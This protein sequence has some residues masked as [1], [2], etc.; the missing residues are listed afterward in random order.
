LKKFLIIQTAFIGDVVL[1]TAVAE[2][3]HEYFP[4]ASIDFMLRKGN[5]SLLEEHPYIRKILVW[6]KKREKYSGLFRLLKTVRK[7]EYDEV[8][9]MQR[10][11]S[12][13]FLTAFSGARHTSGFDKNPF[14]FLF[15]RKV[16]HE[17]TAMGQPLH[18]VDRNQL[19]IA[20][21]TGPQAAKPRLYPNK[22]ALETVAPYKQRP[23]ICIAPAS[24]WFTKQYPK[25]KWISFLKALPAT[26]QVYII[27]APGDAVLADEITREAGSGTNIISLC[28]K[29]S[30]LQ[31]AA[32]QLDA[33]MNYVN[34]SGPLHFASAVNAPVTAIY[35]STVPS[36]GFGPLSD[37]R[38]IVE[39][40]IP[41]N[42]RPCG[43]HGWPACP[44]GHFHCAHYIKDEQL[45]QSIGGL[46]D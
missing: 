2:K 31:S 30:L 46:A 6:D 28:G 20:H 16:P 11:G 17:I 42:C 40:P 9:N 21:I 24:V 4:G 19:L 29:L 34:D 1:A 26:L 41:L 13:G 38:F 18:E 12:T 35:C 36:F 7:E 45:L 15:S 27:G 32:L 10:F 33:R 3:L 23:Y 8:I 44:L 39:T 43:L 37:Q 25:E 22:V 5:E 14:S